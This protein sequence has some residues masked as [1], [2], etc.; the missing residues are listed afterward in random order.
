[1][2]KTLRYSLTLL[3]CLILFACLLPAAYA[4]GGSLQELKNEIAAFKKNPVQKYE[5]YTTGDFMI[6]E[7]LEI[8]KGFQLR[9]LNTLTIAANKVVTVNGKLDATGAGLINILGTVINNGQTRMFNDGV[10]SVS[11]TLQNDHDIYYKNLN[12]YLTHLVIN[13]GASFINNSSLSV[14]VGTELSASVLGVSV[15]GWCRVV[16]GDETDQILYCPPEKYSHFEG[17]C[18]SGEF[19]YLELNGIGNIRV[20]ENMTIPA[21]M[22]VVMSGTTLV[23]PNGKTMTVYGK[24]VAKELVVQQG[25]SFVLQDGGTLIETKTEAPEIAALRAAIKNGQAGYTL[26]SN[27]PIILAE[28]LTIPRNFTLT[29]GTTLQVMP[30]TVLT[31]EDYSSKLD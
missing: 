1:M 14:Q 10:I 6:N 29:V 21:D 9:V 23:V 27:A 20:E 28:A 16:R 13:N 30:G 5:F 4:D 25:G 12:P 17:M 7:N 24:L 18:S 11:G 26:Q 2:S 22:E 3:L 31:L 19:I 15:D 8:P